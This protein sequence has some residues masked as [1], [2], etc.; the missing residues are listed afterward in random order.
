MDV[1]TF[2]NLKLKY[3]KVKKLIKLFEMQTKIQVKEQD[4]YIMDQNRLFFFN[5]SKNIH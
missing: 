5:V 1:L 3:I 4:Q 2:V